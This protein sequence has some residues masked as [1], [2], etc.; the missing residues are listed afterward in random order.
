MNKSAT[1][2]EEL[3]DT[4]EINNTE[5]P[6]IA[7]EPPK[8]NQTSIPFPKL[9]DFSFPED[10]PEALRI[11]QVG[12]VTYVGD[13]VCHVRGLNKVKVEDIVEIHTKPAFRK[14]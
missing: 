8:P 2:I 5:T 6:Q 14:P 13:G 9:L 1:K 7:A 3:I 12:E 10:D 4:I 11:S